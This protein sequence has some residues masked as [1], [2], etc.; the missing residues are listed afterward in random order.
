M[1]IFHDKTSLSIRILFGCARSISGTEGRLAFG[2]MTWPKKYGTH[3]ATG[4]ITKF[5]DRMD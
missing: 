5:K 4:A 3:S 1:Q 2:P